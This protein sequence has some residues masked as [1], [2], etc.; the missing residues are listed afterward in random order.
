MDYYETLAFVPIVLFL[1]GAG[2]FAMWWAMTYG[3]GMDGK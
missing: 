1:V 3:N 2:M